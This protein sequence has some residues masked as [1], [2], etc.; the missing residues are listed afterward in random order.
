M[1]VLLFSLL[2][3]AII[4]PTFAFVPKEKEMYDFVAS[5]ECD[6][7]QWIVG[8]VEEYVKDNRTETYIL[9]KVS[10]LCSIFVVPSYI[11]QVCSK[12]SEI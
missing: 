2:I 8:Y 5:T 9:D 1:K 10:N 11:Q 7:C 12:Y 3:I 4:A 6:L